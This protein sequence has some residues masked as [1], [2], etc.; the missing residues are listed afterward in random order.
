M[1]VGEVIHGSSL[2]S[3]TEG[4]RIMAPFKKLQE[5]SMYWRYRYFTRRQLAVKRWWRELR[6]PRVR[7]QARPRV[8]PMRGRG[9]AAANPFVR[10][11]RVDV[12]RGAAFVLALAAVWTA[13]DLSTLSQASLL[14]GLVRIATLAAVAFLFSRFW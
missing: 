1:Q 2:R 14:I 7:L 5:N 11:D 10:A 12:R 4:Q 8:M 3:S 13:L 9:M 6:R